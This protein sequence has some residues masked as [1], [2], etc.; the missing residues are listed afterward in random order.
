[1]ELFP[2][3]SVQSNDEVPDE[4]RKEQNRFKVVFPRAVCCTC[5]KQRIPAAEMSF[6]VLPLKGRMKPSSEAHPVKIP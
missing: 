6:N 1:M 2:L 4:V 3:K 5:Y